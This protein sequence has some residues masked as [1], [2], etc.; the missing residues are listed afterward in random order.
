MHLHSRAIVALVAAALFAVPAT[1]DAVAPRHPYEP[2]S[3]CVGGY[4]YPHYCSTFAVPATIVQCESHGVIHESSHPWG[5]SG[6]YQIEP[7]TWA[8]YGGLRFT[9]LPYEASKQQQSL[10]ASRIW[11]GGRGASQWSCAYIT[12]WL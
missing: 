7:A 9:R 4:G 10:I 8:A 2:Y 6:L 3:G 12:G 1:G 5:S 11:A